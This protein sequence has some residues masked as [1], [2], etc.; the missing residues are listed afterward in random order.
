M[1]AYCALFRPGWDQTEAQIEAQ[2]AQ[3]VHAAGLP[4]PAVNDVVMVDGRAGI[5]YERIC[6]ISLLELFSQKPWK[7]F[8]SA[9]WLANVHRE[10]HAHC[11]GD[12]P[13]IAERMSARIERLE[14]VP[15]DIKRRLM[16][17]LARVTPG[18]VVCHGDFHPG[19][20]S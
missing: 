1:N 3:A 19:M 7:V 2:K 12:L 8:S 14:G 18:E 4:V 13:S 10:L 16:E 6:G 15:Q 5:I 17:I 20:F 11:L 9:R